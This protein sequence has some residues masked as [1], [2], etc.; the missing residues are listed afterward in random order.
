MPMEAYADQLSNVWRRQGSTASPMLEEAQ[1]GARRLLTPSHQAKLTAS[2]SG[3]LLYQ[4]T[5]Y[6]IEGGDFAQFFQEAH[7]NANV[8]GAQ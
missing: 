2:G 7:A 4:P 1:P 8:T 6:Q 3:V 5:G